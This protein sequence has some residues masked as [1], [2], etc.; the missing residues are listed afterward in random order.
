VVEV[1]F[2]VEVAVVLGDEVTLI[3]EEDIEGF[4]LVVIISMEEVLG[5]INDDENGRLPCH[6]TQYSFPI[7][8]A[9]QSTPGL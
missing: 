8:R 2:I 6:S 1:G 9:K 4:E 5:L 7:T 3:V